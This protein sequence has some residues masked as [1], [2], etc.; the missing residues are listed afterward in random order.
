MI[1]LSLRITQGWISLSY[2]GEGELQKM[3]STP[4]ISKK[5]NFY[6]PNPI[7]NQKP[8]TKPPQPLEEGLYKGRKVACA[9]L[10]FG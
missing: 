8:K 9:V 2:S 1:H 4:N 7:P 10:L 5:L 3:Y 6:M